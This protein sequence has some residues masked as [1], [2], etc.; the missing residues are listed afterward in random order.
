[1]ADKKK[2][3]A[4]LEIVNNRAKYEYFFTATFEAGIILQGTEIQSIRLGHVNLRD[5]YCIFKK[6]ELY[7]RS[8][9]IKEYEFGTY[10]NHEPRRM[11]KLLLRRSE[12]KKLERRVK[13]RGFTIV[14]YKLY[15]SER[16]LAKIEIALSQGKKS[17]DKRQSI[18][19]RDAK[20]DLARMKKQY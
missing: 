14:P 18:K 16:G 4:K 1:M 11:R 20:R 6:G 13:E 17:H 8:M 2:K 9:Y 7:I 10:A 19:E 12:L 3:P 15:L 5:A